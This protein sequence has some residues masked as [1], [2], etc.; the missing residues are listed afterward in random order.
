MRRH[1][2]GLCDTCNVPETV[3]HFI[4]HCT[5]SQIFEEVKAHCLR[6]NIAFNIVNVLKDSE[7]IDLVYGN[8][9]RVI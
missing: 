8:I 1:P 4:M 6:K 2:D 7:Q 3:E 5:E 9:N